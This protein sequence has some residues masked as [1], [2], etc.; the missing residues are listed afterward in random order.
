[1]YSG[2]TGGTEKFPIMGFEWFSKIYYMSKPTLPLL[3][4]LVIRNFPNGKL[5]KK[6]MI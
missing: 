4:I 6:N 5:V 2:I 1:M 3:P